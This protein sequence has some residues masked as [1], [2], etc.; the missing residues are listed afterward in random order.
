MK[1]VHLYSG[2]LDSMLAACLIKQQGIEVIAV[3]FI[4]PF[5]GN[6]E[7]AG[8]TARRL[9]LEFLPVQLGP[10]YLEML[11]KPVY[12][13]G[14][15]FNPCIDCHAFM[16]RQA[17]NVMKEKEASF[18]ISGEVL[19]QRPMSQN[20]NAIQSVDKLS[21]CKGL[22]LRPLSAQLLPETIPAREGWVDVDK[23][24]AISGRSRKPQMEMAQSLGISDYPSPGGGCSLTQENY[25]KRLRQYLNLK[26]ESSLNELAI[27][28]YGRHFML[29]E[30]TLL[31]VGRNQAENNQING[32]ASP[33]DILV[34]TQERPGPLG[35]M[36]G[37]SVN[38]DEA[39]RLAAAIVAT[40]SD[41]KDLVM[42]RVR[43]I[44]GDMT[45]Y[46]EVEPLDRALLPPG[47]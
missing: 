16:F 24:A 30:H 33:G 19:G 2:G 13:Y 38:E 20:K 26:P 40:Y 23:L 39:R 36:R 6:V 35:L 32:L 17:S 5:F 3:H 18:L 34:K 42:A 11:K 47:L 21:G 44:D 25:G 31:V 14:K 12:G 29:D 28:S 7:K 1:A 9:G 37:P 8:D 41:T 15:N 22:I 4:S 27:L 43:M 46:L 10:D 45:D